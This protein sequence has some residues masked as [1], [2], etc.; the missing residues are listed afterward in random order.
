MQLSPMPSLAVR[1]EEESSVV[2]VALAGELDLGGA[3]RVEEALASAERRAPRLLGI[4]LR[5]LT[6][7]D[8]TGLPLV[9]DAD[10]RS[11]RDGRRLVLVR[12]P[13]R[14]SSLFGLTR[15]DERLTM[16]DDP[17]EIGEP[18]AANA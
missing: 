15:V 18:A 14:A 9:L 12:P 1:V 2:R 6:F 13:E 5:A 7:T 10:A 16:V 11:R 8:S 17:A 3:E 4:D